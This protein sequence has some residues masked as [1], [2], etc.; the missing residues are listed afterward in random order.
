M[1]QTAGILL[2]GG[3]STRMGS[4]KALLQIG[5]KTAAGH[6]LQTLQD[7][8]EKQICIA[9]EPDALSFLPVRVTV[10][11]R[12]HEGPLAGIETGMETVDASYYVT[13]ACD[14]PLID[15]RILQWMIHQAAEKQADI[16]LPHID[17][18]DQPLC[19]VYSRSTLPA[20]KASLDAGIRAVKP[21]FD[22]MHTVRISES[23][24]EQAG[25][26]NDSIKRSFFNMNRP[27]E[28]EEMQTYWRERG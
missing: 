20:V 5:D 3:R 15:P 25:C 12:P 13:A 2:A 23:E 9:N 19:A 1:V 10:D 22:Q 24:L 4:M 17:G 8:T 28:Y 18:R 6:V 16:L 7:T 27:E 11:L 26:T 14:M 21:L